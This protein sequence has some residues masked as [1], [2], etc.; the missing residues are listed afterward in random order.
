MRNSQINVAWLGVFLAN[1]VADQTLERGNPSIAGCSER[2]ESR[3]LVHRQERSIL[4]QDLRFPSH[5][6]FEAL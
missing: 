1:P 2:E 3:W 4:E 6:V 5:A